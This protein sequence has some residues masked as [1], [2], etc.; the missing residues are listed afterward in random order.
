MLSYLTN[1]V[2]VI[3][4]I[5]EPSTYLVLGGFLVAGFMLASWKKRAKSKS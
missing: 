4:P 5:P 2:A 3:I 1:L